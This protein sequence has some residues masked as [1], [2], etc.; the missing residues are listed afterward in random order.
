[1]TTY[2]H[3][4]I[5]TGAA[6]NAAT[7][8]SPLAELDAA[9]K[10]NKYDGTTA[11]TV[12]EDSGDGYSVGSMWTD[13]T[14]DEV[15]ICLDATAAAAVWRQLAKHNTYAETGAPGVNDDSGDGYSVGS[16]WIDTTADDAYICL[17]ATSGAAVWKQTTP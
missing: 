4:A 8:N 15:Y 1:M 10:K 3:T 13:V 7:I 6:A 16:V 12:N 14:N 17:D 2:N 5:T 11:P 9:I